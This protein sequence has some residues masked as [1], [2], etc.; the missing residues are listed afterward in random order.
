[1]GAALGVC[2]YGV[3]A[4][5]FLLIIIGFHPLRLEHLTSPFSQRNDSR[6]SHFQERRSPI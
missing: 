6:F 1:M 4:Y 2:E 3:M 5:T